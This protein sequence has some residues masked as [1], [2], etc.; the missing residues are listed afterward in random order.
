MLAVSFALTEVIV[1]EFIGW[2]L[3]QRETK[4]AFGSEQNEVP[5]VVCNR[6]CFPQ[7]GEPP[8]LMRVRGA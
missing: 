5:I 4:A 6:A 8:M 3:E 2:D 1:G 7:C